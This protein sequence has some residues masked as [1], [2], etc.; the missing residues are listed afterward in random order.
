MRRNRFG[1]GFTSLEDRCVLSIFG[2]PWAD[3]EHLTLSL[4]PDGTDAEIGANSLRAT[5]NQ[6]IPQAL[7]ERELYRAFQ[8]WASY[9]NIN[10]GLKADGG[11]AL[12]TSGAVQGDGRF[13][14]IRISA[15]PLGPDAEAHASPF[16]WTG[17]T[18][19]GDVV[20]NSNNLFSANGATDGYDLFTIAL[21]EAG[22]AL[23]LAHSTDPAS[24]M[25]ES[26]QPRTGLSDSDI[27]AIQALYGPRTA[28]DYDAARSN[29]TLASASVLSIG[30]LGGTVVADA[31]LTT[32]SDVDYYRFA[33]PLLGGTATVTLQ[34]A[35]LS[36]LTSKVT[37][38]NAFG[39]AIASSATL[40]PKSNDLTLKFATGLLGG[41]YYAKVEGAN[42]DVFSTGEYRLT[43]SANTIVVPLLSSLLAPATDGNTNDTLARAT[44]LSGQAAGRTDSRFDAIY[45]GK[46]ENAR[47]VDVYRVKA[48]AADASGLNVIVWGADAT[49]LDPTLHVYDENKNPVPFQV[50]ANDTGVFS[51]RIASATPGAT[52][53]IAVQARNA[54]D[55]GAYFVGADFNRD[56]TPTLAEIDGNTLVAD[57][58]YRSTL[59]VTSASVFQ[60]GLAA[61]GA[62]G[63]TMTVY[64]ETGAV[65]FTLDSTAGQPLSTTVRHL[66]AGTYTVVY[67]SRA[68]VSSN[69]AVDFDA[70]LLRL[71]DNAGPY[72]PRTTTTSP[73]PSTSSTYSSG[74]YSYSPAPSSPPPAPSPMYASSS[75]APSQ[76]VGYQY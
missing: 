44:D 46:I 6:T 38:Y 70:M 11:Q 52:Y 1:L 16:S 67:S 3:P 25:S 40:D 37:I 21:H 7:W 20:L 43:V 12:G 58:S 42:R 59:T 28:D 18:Y 36:L 33:A 66:M 56:A 13:G 23:G 24:A 31:D 57:S 27:A 35:G 65:A 74:G 50:L 15:V 47:D 48:P 4:A 68:S 60:F 45:R 9:T 19:S 62:S 2:T 76:G 10:F 49:P 30:L 61:S 39:T 14:D 64:D 8:T 41:T 54:G 29:D 53:Y 73:P 71:S 34:A 32:S 63:L 17:T 51:V 69:A 26:Y 55:T 72:A 5:L 22:H 75:S